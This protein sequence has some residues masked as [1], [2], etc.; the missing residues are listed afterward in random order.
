MDLQN[1]EHSLYYVKGGQLVEVTKPESGYGEC[2]IKWNNHKVIEVRA[3][4]V[5]R[6][7]SD[8]GRKK[9]A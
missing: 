5:D 4:T 6:P 1:K 2:V 7:F 3:T 9:D 8:I